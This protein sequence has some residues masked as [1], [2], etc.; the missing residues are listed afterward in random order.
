MQL[1]PAALRLSLLALAATLAPGLAEARPKYDA[2][3][4][5]DYDDSAIITALFRDANDMESRAEFRVGKWA[6]SGFAAFPIHVISQEGHKAM[7]T[8]TGATTGAF[9]IMG[10]GKVKV[11]PPQSIK[12]V[13]CYEL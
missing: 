3:A 1:L 4:K 13:D 7:C 10:T 12:D 2:S 9:K 5:D 6:F 11:T 8:Y